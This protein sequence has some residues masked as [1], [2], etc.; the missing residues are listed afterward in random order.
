MLRDAALF[1]LKT[2][3]GGKKKKTAVAGGLLLLWSPGRTYF[4]GSPNAISRKVV[5]GFLELD[6]FT[7][8]P[9]S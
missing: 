7:L 5:P 6:S 1:R 2:P 3:R 9:M 8:R 4:L